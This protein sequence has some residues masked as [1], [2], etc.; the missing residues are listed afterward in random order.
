[1]K[2]P[3]LL[4]E[5]LSYCQEAKD[6]AFLLQILADKPAHLVLF[7]ETACGDE[8]WSLNHLT[9]MRQTILW[10]IEKDIDNN[11]E[12][13]FLKRCAS[14]IQAHYPVL[15]E[16][17][18]LNVNCADTESNSLL[19]SAASPYLR[20]ALLAERRED[21]TIMLELPGMTPF[22]MEQIVEQTHTGTVADL[23]RHSDE[24]IYTVLER[25][26]ALEL[27]GLSEI[28]QKI[29]KRYINRVNVFE[30]LLQ[31]HQ[32]RWLI[33]KKDAMA[34]LNAQNFGVTSHDEGPLALQLEF[35]DFTDRALSTFELLKSEVTHLHFTASL[36]DEPPFLELIAACPKLQSLDLSLSDTFSDQLHKLPPTFTS[37]NLSSCPWLTDQQLAALLKTLPQLEE[38]SLASNPQIGFQGWGALHSLPKLSVLNISRCHQIGDEEFKLLIRASPTIVDL[39][40]P[41]CN[42]ITESGFSFLARA[43][44][45]LRSLDLTR[46]AVPL[47]ALVEIA[48]QCPLLME[49]NLTR[50][51]GLS[52]RE[53]KEGIKYAASLRKLILRDF[54][55]SEETLSAIRH[56]S[57]LLE[58]ITD[59]K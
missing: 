33:I 45:D 24:E 58:V 7:F 47:S 27:Q 8:T 32:K 9:F 52:E 35:T 22:I 51:T 42:R 21:H 46:C 44:K 31:A 56:Q 19:L 12:P 54:S 16:A 5:E 28:A 39:I 23:W 50:S 43:L 34:F 1:M 59:G 57:P 30:R 40:M 48:T 53:L 49:L 38:L 41:E 13:I 20:N 26:S 55:I 36:A 17:I 6:D 25:A 37:L 2:L 10:L 14:H 18:P 11:L 4:P 3:A 15:K 29:L